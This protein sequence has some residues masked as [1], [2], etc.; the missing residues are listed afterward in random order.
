[1]KSIFTLF[2]SLN[3]LIILAGCNSPRLLAPLEK[4]EVQV[5]LDAGGPIVGY[6]LPL[7][8]ISAAYGAHER[9][10]PFAGVQLT[11]LMYATLQWD[12]G[13]NIGL[14]KPKKWQPGLSANV[15][16]NGIN[17]FRNNSF[18]IYPEL[19]LNAYWEINEIH[20]PYLTVQTWWDFQLEQTELEKGKIIHPAL[21]IGYQL[22]LKK[23]DFNVEAKWLNFD[24]SLMIP[25][26]RLIHIGG[27][28]AMGVYLKA[29]FRFN[30]KKNK[31]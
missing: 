6:P 2:T 19:A 29:A 12:L 5:G 8:S 18:Y 26:Q 30:A 24:R 20:R 22:H 15:V 4:G 25:Q 16:F 28:G 31:S 1:M 23:W 14:L 7:S 11:S 21:N 3:L 9:I 10:S 17:G 27:F 13:V